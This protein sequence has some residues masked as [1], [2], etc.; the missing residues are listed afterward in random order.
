MILPTG[1]LIEV[2][3]PFPHLLECWLTLTTGMIEKMWKML[4]AQ[5]FC[6]HLL[7]TSNEGKGLEF[8]S[9]PSSPVISLL[10]LTSAGSSESTDSALFPMVSCVESTSSESLSTSSLPLSSTSQATMYV[11]LRL[12]LQLLFKVLMKLGVLQYFNR[13]LRLKAGHMGMRLNQRGLYKNVSI[14]SLLR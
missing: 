5:G 11:S 3:S 8:K 14:P 7:S 2:P 9:V 12:F 4:V 10:V 13:S 1:L 6:R